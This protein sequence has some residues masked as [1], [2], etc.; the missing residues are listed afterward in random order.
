MENDHRQV[1]CRVGA[2]LDPIPIGTEGVVLKAK[3]KKDVE[4]IMNNGAKMK[5]AEAIALFPHHELTIKKHWK[6]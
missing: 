2:C 6:E 1:T 3:E 5:M 4:N